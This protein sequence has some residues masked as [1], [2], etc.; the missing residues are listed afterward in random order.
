MSILNRI[1]IILLIIIFAGLGIAFL[2]SHFLAD[3]YW[4][5][6]VG[7]RQVLITRLLSD[8]GLRLGVISFFFLFFYLNLLFTYRGLNLTPS[9]AR[10]SWTLKEYL[11]DRFVTRR[12][13]TILYLLV[14]LIGALLFS[15]LAAGKWLVVQQYLQAT[16]FGVSDPL[17]TKDVGFY[18]FKLPFYHFLYGMLVTALVGAALVT[19]FFY[20][21]FNPG[22]LLGLSKGRF[23]RPQVHFSTLVA[24]FFLVQAW[25]FRLQAFDLVRS[26]RGVAFGASYTDIH[27]LLPG[28]NILAGVAVACALI[29][30][31]NAFRRNLKLVGIGVLTFIAAYALLVVILPLAVQKFQVE[32]NEFAREEPYLRFNIDFTRRAY[33]LDKITV[34]EFP[35]RDNLTPAD[36]EQEKITLDNIRLWDYRPLQQTYSQLQEIRSYYSFKDIDVDR[37]TIGDSRRQVML[38]A[39]ELDQDKLPDRARTWINEKMRYTHGYGLA[40]NLASTVTPGGQP[41]FIA[42]DL[43]FRSTAGLQLNEPRIYYGELTSDYVITGGKAAEFDYP[44][45][46][47]DNFVETRYE[48]RGGVA[49]N[50]Y[51]RRLI[52]AFRFNDYRLLMSKELTP[53]SKILYYRNIQERVRKIMTY[54]RYDADP[55]LVVAGGRLYWLLDAYTLTSM[56]P[57][58]EPVNEG[59]NYIRNAVKV[60]I[61][62]YN[63]TV[64]YYI[65]DPG[66][67]LS[68]TLGKIF[69]GLFKPLEAMPAELRQHLRYPA[70]LLTI[71]ARMLASYHMENT[72]LFYN[73]EDAWN[74]AEEMVGDQRRA[75]EPYYTLLRLPG[76]QEAEYILMLPFTPAR[77]VNMVAWLAAR[78]D[79]PHYGQLLLY[80]FPKNRSIY[81]PMQIEARI[82]QEPTISQQLTLWD[83]HGSRVIRGNLLVLPIKEALLYV[84]PI[85][86]QAQESKLPEL[87]QV[88]VA[89]GEKIVMAD[90]L[91]GALK[92][93]FGDRAP[94]TP[95]PATTVPPSGPLTTSNLAT[96]IQEANRLYSEAQEKLKLGDWAGYGENMKKLGQL[97]QEMQQNYRQ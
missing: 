74:I 32:P 29:I 37:Y 40:M 34:R 65:V 8:W 90:T 39:R 66:D 73:K 77:K 36:L 25:G 13:L 28:Y 94:V 43:P 80:T 96:S 58:S 82:D 88:V 91:A 76:E 47:G 63:G 10:E 89:Y 97:L 22:E 83:Q 14:S 52:F 68:Q 92:A 46:G 64:D 60:V 51:W 49:L 41:E 18:V 27:A 93:I 9:P 42:G 59:F 57:Y 54:L 61:D 48:G 24:L 26:P 17:F 15:P 85:F 79:G 87:R 16:N 71:Q 55:Y 2:G 30:F 7:Y 72:M 1:R 70:E 86:L 44:S 56:Y 69:P 31:L 45:S 95:P 3:W 78:N 53:Q 20:L 84:E 33:G 11:V 5:G 75:M 12:R 6:E 38:S 19:G 21:L 50:N 35:A 67:P 4:F 23:A 81:G 62:A